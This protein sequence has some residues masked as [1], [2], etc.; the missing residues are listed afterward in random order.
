M[1]RN[2]VQ[3]SAMT[4]AARTL[5]QSYPDTLAWEKAQEVLARYEIALDKKP[6]R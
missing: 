1:L 2:Q 5:K 6:A 4:T 3:V